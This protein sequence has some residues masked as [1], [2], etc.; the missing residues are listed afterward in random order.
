MTAPTLKISPHCLLFVWQ[1]FSGHLLSL[2]GYPL[3]CEYSSKKN[4]HLSLWCLLYRKVMGSK[5]R[6]NFCVI[7]AHGENGAGQA[8]WQHLPCK[9][10]TF[11]C[12][13]QQPSPRGRLLDNSDHHNQCSVPPRFLLSHISGCTNCY[14]VFKVMDTS[15]LSWCLWNPS[16]SPSGSCLYT[17]HAKL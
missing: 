4:K 7:T 14:S 9:A 16:F 13:L 12:G 8:V 10:Q 6:E 11:W 3:H 17:R 2:R 15:Y 1:I 5:K